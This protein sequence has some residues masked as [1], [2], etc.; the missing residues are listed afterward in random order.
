MALHRSANSAKIL[1]GYL[2]SRI[3]GNADIWGFPIAVSIEPTTTCNLRCPQC[4]TGRGE[5]KRPGGSISMEL[6]KS[7]IDQLLP[8]LSYLTLY[9]QGEPFL[10]RDFTEMVSYARSKKIFVATST[11]GHFLDEATAMACVES[12]LNRIIVSLDG[13]TP[14]SYESY[15]AGGNF[16]KVTQGIRNLVNA[17][18]I[19]GK[20]NPGIVLQCLVLKSNQHELR[21]IRDLG[22]TLG[23]DKVEFKSAQFYDFEKGDPLMPD[24]GKYARYSSTGSAN[25]NHALK[26]NLAN[27][28]F[29][30]WSSCVITWD[31]KV[32]PCCFDKNAGHILGDITKQP[33][34]EIWNDT[35]YREF[36]KRLLSD[37][38]SI[39]ICRNCTQWY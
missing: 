6:F 39:E 5:L 1:L 27:H 3:T 12:G 7:A 17:R 20:K 9:F 30:M 35:P 32:V 22:R 13:A 8:Q 36:R 19:A 11:N 16:E 37:R 29:R 23:A 4:V 15:R 33:F 10:H 21:F 24:P 28:C 31:G 25:G 18:K 38:K 14:E 34:R 26:N 2:R